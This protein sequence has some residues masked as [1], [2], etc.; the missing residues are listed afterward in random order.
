M[1]KTSWLLKTTFAKGSLLYGILSHVKTVPQAARVLLTISNISTVQVRYVPCIYENTAMDLSYRIFCVICSI[2]TFDFF[3]YFKSVNPKSVFF[4]YQW[5][6][7][8]WAQS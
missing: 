2:N 5:G 1:L 4:F 8:T 7:R 6:C 3:R